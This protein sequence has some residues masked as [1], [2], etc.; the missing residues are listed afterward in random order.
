MNDNVLMSDLSEQDV[1][2]RLI[3]PALD[4]AGWSA[5]KRRA[6][7]SYRKDYQF[8]DG[9]IDVREGKVARQKGK[10][11]D[12]LLFK[13]N[14]HAIA[15]VE[16]KDANHEVGDGLQQAKD[17]ARDLDLKFAYASNGKGFIE[18]DF[19]T[20]LT[21]KFG[22]NDFP[23]LEELENRYRQEGNISSRSQ[24]SSRSDVDAGF[25]VA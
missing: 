15:V 23:Q 4:K 3:T 21:R 12:Y 19:F 2:D 14:S 11:V 6:E 13:D 20:G 24:Y 16:A 7:Y 17:Y 1:R 9:R 8:T 25:Q 22:M 18:Y 10:R 5:S